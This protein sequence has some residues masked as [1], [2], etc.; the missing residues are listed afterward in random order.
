MKTLLFIIGLISMKIA[1]DSTIMP[2][3]PTIT[4][5]IHGTNPR[6]IVANRIKLIQK[7]DNTLFACK[8]GLHKITTFT[9]DQHYYL[10]AKELSDN[11]P[12]QF[13]WE[14]FYV[15]GWPGKLDPTNRHQAASNLYQELSTLV[16][17]YQKE[18]H[19]IPQINLITHSHGGNVALKMASLVDKNCSFSINRLILLACPVQS[20]T[21]DLIKSPFFK[22]IYSIHSHTDIFQVLD[23]QGLHPFFDLK[24][25]TEF[26]NAF[27]S[28]KK[29]PLFSQRHF[30]INPKI[31]HA[32]IRWTKG[33]SWQ[34]PKIAMPINTYFQSIKIALQ[35]IDKIKANRGLTHIEFT[36]LPFVSHLPQIIRQLDEVI[37]KTMHCSN[38][39]DPDIII[40][41]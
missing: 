14:N 25:I 40:H 6:E 4:I 15:F 3:V 22:K 1:A 8:Q 9:S 34:K 10:L 38:N 20:Y 31:V 32:C 24:N 26:K 23:P 28:S 29:R 12:Q 19:F 16:L 13:G 33:V 21:I 35:N 2:K 18:Y 7:F 37:N 5:W 30:P 39:A 36:L 27:N 41:L 17:Q 11:W